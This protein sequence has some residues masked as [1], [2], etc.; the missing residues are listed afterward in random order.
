MRSVSHSTGARSSV[1]G[2]LADLAPGAR[3]VRAGARSEASVRR[4]R[5]R[6]DAAAPPSCRGSVKPRTI[7]LKRSAGHSRTCGK[8]AA[9]VPPTAS[10]EPLVVGH[11]RDVQRDDAA[12]TRGGPARAGRTRGSRDR[13]ARTAG[14][15]RR[16][17]SG[18][19][20]RPSSG[21]TAGRRRR[22]PSGVGCRPSRS[23]ARPTRLTA[24]SSST[25]SMLA[26]G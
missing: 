7:V 6:A 9:S 3:R 26:S 14:G 19:T 22:A 16:R 24:G 15:T 17:R 21:G 20:A 5:S 18:R 1:H 12:G 23:T 11:R 4:A 25:P 8:S 10:D 13:R 2:R